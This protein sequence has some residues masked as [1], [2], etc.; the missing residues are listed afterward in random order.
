MDHKEELILL[1]S[2]LQRLLTEYADLKQQ[3]SILRKA[4]EAQH[5]EIMR[6]HAELV[7]L[8]KQYD[9]LRTAH[10]L[11]AATEDK[12]RAKRIITSIITKIDQSIELINA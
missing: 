8:R 7:Q 11:T 5:E 10:A 4:N 9:L 3:V 6:S 1:Q 12:E 2:N